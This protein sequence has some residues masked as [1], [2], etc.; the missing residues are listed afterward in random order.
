MKEKITPASLF[1]LGYQYSV[2][3][4]K[5]NITDMAC[6]FIFLGDNTIDFEI[7]GTLGLICNHRTWLQSRSRERTYPF[8]RAEQYISG[9][10]LSPSANFVYA[11]IDDVT[12]LLVDKLKNDPTAV[13]LIDTYNEHG[14]AEQRRLFVKLMTSKC[15]V[16]VIIGRAYKDLSLDHLQLY[17]ATDFGG[18]L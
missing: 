6:D 8:I 16:P 18:Y 12:D 5:W 10:E 15:E 9:V 1:A 14:M 17:A 7:P 11:C 3:L 4:D 2:P 13:L